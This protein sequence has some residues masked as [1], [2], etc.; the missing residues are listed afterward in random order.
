MNNHKNQNDA[1]T[2]GINCKQLLG[3]PEP[4]ACL[5]V[6]NR[7]DAEMSGL[8]REYKPPEKFQHYKEE[9]VAELK[10]ENDSDGQDVEVYETR[11][12]A[13]YYR[14]KVL[15]TPNSMGVE[16]KDYEIT[17]SS[18]MHKLTCELAKA[19]AEGKIRIRRD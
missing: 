6:G 3:V 8:G 9:L 16:Q 15:S 14:I 18:S 1:T 7:F 11:M 10:S 17:T 19:I 2:K 5:Y 12:P 4:F 13:T